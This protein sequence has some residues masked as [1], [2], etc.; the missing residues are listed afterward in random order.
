MGKV[1]KISTIKKEVNLKDGLQTMQTGLL[2]KGLT[3]TPGTGVFKFP[4]K[5]SGNRYQTGLDENADYIKR[6]IDEDERASEIK[7]VTTW[8]KEIAE[9]L[10]LTESDLSP[11]SKFWNYTLYKEGLDENHV[12]PVKLLDGDNFFNL[13][14]VREKIA[15]AWLRV[16]PTVAS[17]F[18]AYERGEYGP[19][20]QFYVAD[21]ERDNE[22]KF[23]K[24]QTI[25]KAISEW[26]DFT[27]SKRRKIAR[28]MGLPVTEDSKDEIVY[29]LVDDVLKT[30]EIKVGEYKGTNPVTLFNRFAHMKENLL[31]LN[32]LVEQAIHYNVYRAKNGGKLYEGEFKV[33]DSKSELV[34]FLMDEDNQSDLIALKDKLKLK[35]LS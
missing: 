9:E 25:N 29:N 22:V 5:V 19:D 32:D 17:S 31:E 34:E 13:E 18:Q 24:K 8:R 33:S 16:H 27:P 35:Q 12:T 6:I 15:F 21:D 28:M 26:I 1:V 2:S 4:Y 3:R 7:K 11:T 14:N 23:K 20:V 30:S 10:G